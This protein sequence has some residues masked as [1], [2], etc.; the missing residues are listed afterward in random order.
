M[1]NLVFFTYMKQL[2]GKTIFDADSKAFNYTE[3]DIQ[4]CLDL[5]KSLY[6]N[7]VCAPA[8]YSSAYSNDDLQ[9]DPNWIAGKYVCT[10][11][12]ISTINV[13][14]AANEGATYGTGYLPLLDGAKDNGWACNCPQV[15]AVTST[16]KAPEAAM[17]FL[18]Y[19][20]NSDDAESTLACVRR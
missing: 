4:N 10:F 16:C 7:N 8:S 1:T 2:T 19:F 3:E 20:F 14:T 11:A 5:V 6:D 15:L 18:D 12:Y 13:M 9:S 17:K